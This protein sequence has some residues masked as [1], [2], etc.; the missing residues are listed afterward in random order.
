[1]QAQPTC[2]VLSTAPSETEDDDCRKHLG[3]DHLL[4]TYGYGNAANGATASRAQRVHGTADLR[5]GA[6]A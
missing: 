5:N 2:R 4:V 3:V 6:L 1:M